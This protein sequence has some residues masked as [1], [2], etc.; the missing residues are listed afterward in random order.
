MGVHRLSILVLNEDPKLINK[1][2]FCL[3]QQGFE[4][5]HAYTKCE[6]KKLLDAHRFDVLVTDVTMPENDGIELSKTMCKNIP[7]VLLTAGEGG[8]EMAR[9]FGDICDCFLDKS[10]IVS[11]LG[12][13]T[14]KAFKRFK[15]DREI[16][17]DDLK[18]L[19]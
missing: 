19:A 2:E 8:G 18:M 3:K 11:R 6:A 7:I 15:I 9:N 12:Q 5:S 10:D 16:V 1:I 4:T 17:R 14:W 13:A